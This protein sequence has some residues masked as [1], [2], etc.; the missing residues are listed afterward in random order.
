MAQGK[1]TFN[2]Y[3]DMLSV[4]EQLPDAKAGQLIKH[5]FK[6]VN[7]QNPKTEDLLLKVAFEPIK[8][9]LKLDLKKWEEK[10]EKNKENVLKRWNKKD[11]NVYE[12]I[13]IDTKHTDKDKDKDKDIIINIVSFLNQLTGSNYKANTDK[14]IKQISA[15]FREGFTLDDFKKV[16]KTKTLEWKGT[17]FEKY[18]R[19]ETL[20][21]TKVFFFL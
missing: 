17:D 20:F 21:G 5:I 4:F 3:C 1:K 13:P 7:D 19:P 12:R 15:R 2:L 10:C 6:Y 16:I 8:N 9:K 14:T 11:S 18:L